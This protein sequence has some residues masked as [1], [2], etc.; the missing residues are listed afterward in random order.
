[1]EVQIEATPWTIFD[2]I[3]YK[4]DSTIEYEYSEY[5]ERVAF[6][7]P[8]SVYNLINQDL[9]LPLMIS[10]SFIHVQ[11]QIVNASNGAN[12]ATGNVALTNNGF[13]IFQRVEYYMDEQ[14]VESLDLPGI[15]TTVKGL[16]DYSSAYSKNS[17]ANEFW[18]P[19]TGFG[20][21]NNGLTF[22]DVTQGNAICSYTTGAANQII[23]TLPVQ[24]PALSFANAD[25]IAVYLY[26]KPLSFLRQATAT[27]LY[28]TSTPS[29]VRIG[30]GPAYPT[31]TFT[32]SAVAN[33]DNIRVFTSY[34]EEVTLFA[35]DIN[36]RL[37][38][39]ATPLTILSGA[40]AANLPIRARAAGDIN[41]NTGFDKRVLRSLSNADGITSNKIINLYLPI[42]RMF[43]LFEYNQQV[44]KGIKHQM[45]LYK[46][47]NNKEVLMTTNTSPLA[48]LNI[49]NMSWWVPVLRPSVDYALK[50]NAQLNEG[51]ST[52]LMWNQLT[53]ITSYDF[54]SGQNIGGYTSYRIGGFSDKPVRVYIVFRNLNQYNNG[55]S[56]SAFNP[57]VFLHMNITN[58]HIRLNNTQYP[59]TEYLA[60]FITNN[61][62]N[63][64]YQQYSEFSGFN[65]AEGGGVNVNYDDFKNLYP[66]F[67]F[68]LSKQ[69]PEIWK[70]RT[71]VEMELRFIRT[72]ELAPPNNV[73]FRFHAI[74]E[75]EKKLEI[76]GMENRMSLI[77]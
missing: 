45:T 77:V 37:Q 28:T 55:T 2:R 16:I 63:R 61:E 51:T 65:D 5:K 74:I 50:L 39:N 13:N 69:E 6:I 1:M 75:C 32:L 52:K 62:Y 42:K 76:K 20:D 59:K 54:A 22:I 71:E 7:T 4:D 25:V 67:C 44:F 57:M 70:N 73:T 36:V 38:G 24:V 72:A 43:K 40:V 29:I 19:D 14:L 18:Y 48:Q 21:N 17:L 35:N 11:C 53:C 56:Q 66:I 58:I 9:D 41:L 27:G 46:N 34:G 30:G 64:L 31:A 3:Y 47:L 26:N 10:D 68:D 8:N 49:I 15:A 33:G 23:L 12:I 60:D